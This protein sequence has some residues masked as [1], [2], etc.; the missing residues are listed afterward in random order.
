MGSFFYL[1]S[2]TQSYNMTPEV[3]NIMNTTGYPLVEATR[4]S[5]NIYAD[6]YGEFTGAGK[7]K[8]DDIERNVLGKLVEQQ[9]R[10][11]NNKAL[12]ARINNL[13]VGIRIARNS[14]NLSVG[15]DAIIAAYNNG[16][17]RDSQ[18]RPTGRQYDN[19]NRVVGPLRIVEIK[20]NSRITNQ[21]NG[22]SITGDILHN[23]NPDKQ[24]TPPGV[25]QV[26]PPVV[27][28]GAPAI[29]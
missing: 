9:K 21:V 28:G 20:T 6:L 19:N 24:P 26:K 7:K 18:N 15:K 17:L 4:R 14:R 16:E 2:N 27:R 13:R 3:N 25:M 23:G 11:P 12:A 10:E 1:S 8:L 5:G 22:I 29:R